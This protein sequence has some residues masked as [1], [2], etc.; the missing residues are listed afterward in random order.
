MDEI[1]HQDLAQDELNTVLAA[2]VQ[3]EMDQS[4]L[5]CPLV[6]DVYQVNE[7]E[8]LPCQCQTK[9]QAYFVLIGEKNSAHQL[10]LFLQEAYLLPNAKVYHFMS[11]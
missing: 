2:V 10:L 5:L 6:K 11:T 4:N 3:G 9:Y 8:E 7:F 1:S